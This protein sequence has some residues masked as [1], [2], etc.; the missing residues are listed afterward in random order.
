MPVAGS[1]Q[2]AVTVACVTVSPMTAMLPLMTP[3]LSTA[4][5][6]A[7]HGIIVT[8]I[9]V[10]ANAALVNKVS[11]RVCFMITFT[12]NEVSSRMS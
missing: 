7:R 5:A 6:A 9:A 10:R 12:P 4:W 8:A 11:A 3:G 2:S 1:V